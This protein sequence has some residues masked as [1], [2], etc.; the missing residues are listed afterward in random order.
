MDELNAACGPRP[1]PQF[2][3][4]EPWGPPIMVPNMNDHIISPDGTCEKC[5]AVLAVI[6]VSIIGGV[7]TIFFGWTSTIILLA[8]ISCIAIAAGFIN[9]D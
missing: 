3:G 1:P 9:R 2:R 4:A 6:V 7:L 8:L 5:G